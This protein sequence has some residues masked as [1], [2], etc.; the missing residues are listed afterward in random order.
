MWDAKIV[1]GIL[2]KSIY[3]LFKRNGITHVHNLNLILIVTENVLNFCTTLM[4]S[5]QV[6]LITAF[7][8]K[9]WR[10]LLREVKLW[11]SQD[12]TAPT[13]SRQIPRDAA[14]FDLS[15]FILVAS[16]LIV[17]ETERSS[18]HHATCSKTTYCMSMYVHNYFSCSV[19]GATL[20]H[21]LNGL[22]MKIFLPFIFSMRN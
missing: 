6:H 8:I 9:K 19:S 15:R 1:F 22:F 11:S 13:G 12:H 4:D 10:R 16:T 2:N 14:V 17:P 3:H 21:F 5:Q 7:N 20:K 18:L